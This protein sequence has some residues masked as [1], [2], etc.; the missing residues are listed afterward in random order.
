MENY[1]YK[2]SGDF[3]PSLQAA[4]SRMRSGQARQRGQLAE[5]TRRVRT[6]GVRFLPAETLERGFADAEAG[7]Y[8]D[9]AQH[10]AQERVN[11]RRRQED[12]QFERE[13]MERGGDL[14]K[15]IAR[16]KLQGQLW[17]TGIGLVGG[18]AHSALDYY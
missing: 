13:M 9:F 17:G 2:P 16:R 12:F 18:A 1:G 4:I 7:L 8:G 15:T 11:D 6:S 14:Q 3:E 10:D 5:A